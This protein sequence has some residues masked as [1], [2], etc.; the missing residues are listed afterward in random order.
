[1]LS[2]EFTDDLAILLGAISEA[3]HYI[4]G[5]VDTER[6]ICFRSALN[7]QLFENELE[8]HINT[9]DKLALVCSLIIK[10][11]DY[12]IEFEEFGRM[13]RNAPLI[14]DEIEYHLG[15][16][17]KKTAAERNSY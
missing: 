8:S 11:L 13:V 5:E 9:S 1:M 6:R 7:L 16:Y 2:I 15:I 12:C 17:E 4:N 10:S 14:I 3:L